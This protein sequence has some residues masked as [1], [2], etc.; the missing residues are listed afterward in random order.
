MSS[1]RERL[2]KVKYDEEYAKQLQ[3]LVNRDNQTDTS[4]IRDRLS[5]IEV[6]QEYAKEL[7]TQTLNQEIKS[8]MDKKELAFQNYSKNKNTSNTRFPT[9]LDNV[10]S[11][12][13]QMDKMQKQQFD[14]KSFNEQYDDS[15]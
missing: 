10:R 6:D 9:I 7:Q 4:S 5:K 15:I 3:S 8:E 11:S 12:N 1:I 2:S 13:N 14:R